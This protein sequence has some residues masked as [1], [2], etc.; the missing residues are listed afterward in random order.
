MNNSERRHDYQNIEPSTIKELFAEAYPG[1]E[2]VG[3]KPITTG[4]TNSNIKVDLKSARSV[5]LRIQ[6]SGIEKYKVEA[7]ALETVRNTVS[8][9]KVLFQSERWDSIGYPVMVVEYVDGVLLENALSSDEVNF[10]YYL[11]GSSVAETLAAIFEHDFQEPVY[12]TEDYFKFVEHALSQIS[13]SNIL[14]SSTIKRIDTLI[15]KNSALVES[16]YSKLGLVHSDFK[17][18]N[19][20]VDSDGTKVVAVIDWEWAHK[21]T[22]FS[23][24]GN[25]LRF[26]DS[27]P[28]E[29]TTG[30][31]NRFNEL[32]GLLR[33]DWEKKASLIDLT[34]H[35]EKIISFKQ[36][37]EHNRT[38]VDIIMRTLNQYG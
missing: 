35:L 11:I 25:F 29:L 33:D 12:R 5:V 28:V 17:P 3:T 38:S 19:I 27:Y 9:P 26:K 4:F 14:D 1:E 10:D 7:N 30:F 6:T 16:C 2:V 32:T 24:I 23:D 31:T 34:A 21:G 18:D 8:V 15:Q 20:I 37:T 36:R 22:V 13:N